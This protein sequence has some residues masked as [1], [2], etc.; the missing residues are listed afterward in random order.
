M[1]GGIAGNKA[2]TNT[3]NEGKKLRKIDDINEKHYEVSF[4]GYQG[5]TLNGTKWQG[6]TRYNKYKYEVGTIFKLCYA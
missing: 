1:R 5:K 6:R 4:F 3:I 2:T